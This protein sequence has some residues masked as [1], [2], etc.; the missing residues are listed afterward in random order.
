MPGDPLSRTAQ[1][2]TWRLPGNGGIGRV[3]RPIDSLRPT[4]SIAQA[5]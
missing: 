2:I 3:D 1:H 5:P 4:G